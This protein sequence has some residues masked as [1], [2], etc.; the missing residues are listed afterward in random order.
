MQTDKEL[1]ND[2]FK[3]LRK[4]GYFARQNFWCCQTCACA[5][6][7]KAKENKYVFY[8]NQDNESIK[9]GNIDKGGMYLA[10]SGNGKQIVDIIRATGLNVTWNG[11]ETTRICINSQY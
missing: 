7:P 9:N 5:A 1:L 10:W 2:A 11:K 8:H 4:Q 3:K 6:I